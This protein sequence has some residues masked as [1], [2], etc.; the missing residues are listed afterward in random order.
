MRAVPQPIVCGVQ[1]AAGG[2]GFSL[3][4]AADVRVAGETAQ[5]IAS[6]LTIGLSGAFCRALYVGG[7]SHALAPAGCE[8]GTSFF[9]PK[10]VGLSNASLILMTGEAVSA[11]EAFRIGLV[12]KVV[13]DAQLEAACVAIAQKMLGASALGLVLTKRQLTA[14]ADG[15]SLQAAIHAENVQQQLCLNDAP[16]QTFTADKSRRFVEAAKKKAAKL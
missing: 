9:L 8:L 6:F 2:G 7:R 12:S 16:T 14:A 15:Q 4:L 13:P 11:N 10:M 5:F 3:A 1:G